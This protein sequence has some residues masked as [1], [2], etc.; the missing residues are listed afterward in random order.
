M[1]F[2]DESQI[3]SSIAKVHVTLILISPMKINNAASF[4]EISL[5]KLQ[6]P[7]SASSRVLAA[8]VRQIFPSR[9]SEN[10][11]TSGKKRKL[12]VVTEK[13]PNKKQR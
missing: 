9:K 13:K 5:H 6:A 11:H 10:N 1:R 3:Q 2:H 8:Y 7:C 12:I 4:P